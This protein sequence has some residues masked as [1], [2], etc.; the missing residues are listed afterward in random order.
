MTVASVVDLPPHLSYSSKSAYLG[1]GERFRL[2]KVEK[3][4]GIPSWAMVGGSAVHALTESLD[5]RL[6][7]V[8]GEPDDF[9]FN[10]VFDKNIAEQVERCGFD[11]TEWKATGRASKA[12]PNKEDEAFWRTNGPVFVNNWVTWLERTG[13]NV[14][15]TPEGVPAIEVGLNPIFGGIPIKQ[16]V[17]RVM[18]TPDGELVVVDLKS[19]TRVPES[20]QL[21][22]YACGLEQQFGPAGRPQY[23]VYWMARQA[24]TS[25]IFN[26]DPYTQ[27]RVAFEYSTARRGMEAGI[28]L[29]N[30]TA[31]CG[32]CGVR[33]GCYAVGGAEAHKYLPFGPDVKV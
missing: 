26:L 13:W 24:G 23:G 30:P 31:L 6:F 14:W 21:G 8:D 5:R 3:V 12:N 9:D 11:T 25:E 22:H 28:F 17:D 33:R 2:E 32:G 4:Q 15:L 20:S 27:E 29:P 1:C 7:G 16:Y 18:V 19:G 10:K